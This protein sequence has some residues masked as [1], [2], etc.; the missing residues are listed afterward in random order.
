[1]LSSHFKVFKEARSFLRVPIGG[2][3]LDRDLKV[4]IMGA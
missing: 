3:P 4:V 2:I 1:M